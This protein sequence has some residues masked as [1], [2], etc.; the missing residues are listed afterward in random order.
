VS[1]VIPHSVSAKSARKASSA[2]LDSTSEQRPRILG[3]QAGSRKSGVDD[4]AWRGRSFRRHRGLTWGNENS[5]NARATEVKRDPTFYQGNIAM[6]SQS[7]AMMTAIL[8]WA[9]S[10]NW[11]CSFHIS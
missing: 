8:D 7:G 3:C 9:F 11:I 4:V 2:L 5:F 1:N 10:T 6:I